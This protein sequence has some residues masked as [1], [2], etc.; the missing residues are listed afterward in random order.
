MS[1][2]DSVYLDYYKACT[3][4]QTME[5]SQISVTGLIPRTVRI[6]MN[7]VILSGSRQISDVEDILI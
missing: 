5:L 2:S 6:V 3:I 4:L 1:F 7:N